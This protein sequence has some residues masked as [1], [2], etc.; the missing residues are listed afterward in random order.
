M[1]LQLQYLSFSG[2]SVDVFDL[3]TIVGVD[4]FDF[5][6]IIALCWVESLVWV[7]WEEGKLK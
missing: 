5:V 6:A 3:A 4:V 7:R 1:S 2:V